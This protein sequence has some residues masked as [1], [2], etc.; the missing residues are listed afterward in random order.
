MTDTPFLTDTRNLK[1]VRD[2]VFKEAVDVDDTHFINCVFDAAQLRYGGGQRPNFEN[3]TF[4]AV[5]WLFH[6]AALRTIQLLQ[7][8]NLHGE[9][10]QMIDDIFRAGQLFSD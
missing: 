9:N 10:Q 2:Q 3:C 8:Q 5:G 4:T 1:E 6:G 7:L